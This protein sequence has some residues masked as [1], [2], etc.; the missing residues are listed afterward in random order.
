MDTESELNLKLKEFCHYIKPPDT[1]TE[2]CNTT[3][4]ELINL[5]TYHSKFKICHYVIGGG[6]P[7]G[8]NTSTCLKADADITVYVEWTTDKV[9]DIQFYYNLSAINYHVSG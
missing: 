8:K 7:A 9:N 6:L 5:I 2:L 3:I 1:Y 4:Q